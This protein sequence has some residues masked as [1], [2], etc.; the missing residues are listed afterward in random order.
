MPLKIAGKY[1]GTEINE[2]WWRRYTKD[3][4]LARGNGTFSY[5]QAVIKFLRALTKTPIEI[6]FKEI[7]GFKTG[8]WH[9][10]QWG[11]GRKIIKV[12]WQK[13]SRILCSGFAVAMDNTAIGRLISELED[14]LKKTGDNEGDSG[15]GMSRGI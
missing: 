6:N 4:M 8:K 7:V 10:G 2:K 14:I 13:E 9:A 3:K 12:I 11:G 15:S 5:D 1:F